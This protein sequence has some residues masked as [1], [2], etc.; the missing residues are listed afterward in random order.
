MS[1]AILY[2]YVIASFTFN[3]RIF[4]LLD[5]KQA[6]LVLDHPESITLK[7][8]LRVR[9]ICGSISINGYN[10]KS[11]GATHSVYSPE[12][13][14]LLS[15]DSAQGYEGDIFKVKD[16]ISLVRKDVNWRSE[17][18]NASS[19]RRPVIVLLQKMND[20]PLDFVCSFSSY[21][22]LFSGEM[23][24]RNETDV[25]D[26][27]SL[28]VRLYGPGST[29]PCLKMTRDFDNIKEW[30]SSRLLKGTAWCIMLHYVYSKSAVR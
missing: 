14:S 7:G 28:G 15:V 6:L 5:P 3:F 25:I 10:I 30:L 26:L 8:K 11:D 29:V 20:R 16:L 17:L 24:R 13:H 2:L 4:P 1:V 23:R 27:N 21:V 19:C 22:S 18:Q 9:C 12:S